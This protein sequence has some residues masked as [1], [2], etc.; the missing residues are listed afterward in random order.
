MT[1]RQS[2][3]S[4]KTPKFTYQVEILQVSNEGSLKKEIISFHQKAEVNLHSFKKLLI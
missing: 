4:F 1:E 3:C 2:I